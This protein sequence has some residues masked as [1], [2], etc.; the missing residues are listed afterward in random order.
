MQLSK[1]MIMKKVLALAVLALSF[2]SA[3]LH[4]ALGVPTPVPIPDPTPAPTPIP[5]PA[6]APT[7]AP[8]TVLPTGGGISHAV[9]E[10][11]HVGLNWT[12]GGSIVPDA[13][14]GFRHANVD[15]NGKT[16]GSDLSLS[17]PLTHI[18][19]GKLKVQYFEGHINALG[20]VGLGYDF[21]SKN[22][23]ATARAQVPHFYFGSDYVFGS[24]FHPFVGITSEKLSKP[25]SIE[26]TTCP[27]SYTFN[28]ET[29]LCM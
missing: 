10:K 6:P 21:D 13:V 15:S 24:G 2:S 9:D 14:I 22:F 4:A 3:Q 25:A 11:F 7:P 12:L 27:V 26:A 28:P 8:V 16:H 19:L 23:L 17:I 1:G 20:E 5:T 18:S 29:G